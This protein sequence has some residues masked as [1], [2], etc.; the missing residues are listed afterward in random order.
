MAL[1][2][3]TTIKAWLNEEGSDSDTLFT[4]L[5]TRVTRWWEE[6]TGRHLDQ[7]AS[8]TRYPQKSGRPFVLALPEYITTGTPTVSVRDG[9]VSEDWEELD[10]TAFEVVDDPVKNTSLIIKQDGIEWPKGAYLIKVVYTTGYSSGTLPGDIQGALLE[11]CGVD[12][13]NRPRVAG[14]SSALEDDGDGDG[15]P[16]KLPQKTQA[17]LERWRAYRPLSGPIGINS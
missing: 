14:I 10:A 4:E 12:Y 5:E 11:S 7:E 1:L 2:T 9:A 16:L 13:R 6:Q 15:K 8:V 3:N 17:V